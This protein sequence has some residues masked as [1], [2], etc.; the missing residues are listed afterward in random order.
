MMVEGLILLSANLTRTSKVYI[1]TLVF[2][3][4]RELANQV[5]LAHNILM[6]IVL[7]AIAFLIATMCLLYFRYKQRRMKRAIESLSEKRISQLT[8]EKGQLFLE[9][10]RLRDSYLELSKLLE[11]NKEIIH[12]TEIISD[13]LWH[14]VI[15]DVDSL[16]DGY[17][18]RLKSQFTSLKESDIHFC[19]LLK[20]GFSYS[21]IACLLGRTSNMMYKRRD[22]IAKRMRLNGSSNEIDTFIK[23]F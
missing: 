4:N 5:P 22:L 6:V 10:I 3:T 8:K 17:T 7:I 1:D 16:T 15:E 23:S 19:C 14:K 11:S 18:S 13:T 9:A 2:N 20:M 12:S 21:E